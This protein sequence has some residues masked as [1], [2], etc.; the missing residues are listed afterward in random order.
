MKRLEKKLLV[1]LLFLSSAFIPV[2]SNASLDSTDEDHVIDAPWRTT[3]QYLPV[4]FFLPE[5]KSSKGHTLKAFRLYN[6][7]PATKEK[8]SIFIDRRSDKDDYFRC[9]IDFINPDGKPR[10]NFF[11]GEEIDSFWHYIAR[12]PVACIG[13]G[14][15]LG[16][17][18]VHYLYGEI[19]WDKNK[20]SVPYID[21]NQ[22]EFKVLRV[23]VTDKGFA[24]FSPVDHQFDVH[25]HTIA[26]QTSWSPTNVNAARSK[27]GG[28]LAML[29]ES[30]YA[31]G[32]VDVELKD[33]NWSD[34]KNKIITTDHNVF[35]SGEAYDSGTRPGYGPTSYKNGGQQEFQWYRDN[36]GALGGEEITVQGAHGVPN[37]PQKER[38]GSHLLSYGS[39][40]IDGPW[41]GGKFQIDIPAAPDPVGVPNQ[42]SISHA[43]ERMGSSNGFGY[44]SHPESSGIGWSK[45]Y[46][47]KAIGLAQ[48][49]DGS[50]TSVILQKNGSEFVLKGLQVWNQHKDMTSRD[51]GDIED[52]R[53]SR[54]DP[55]TPAKAGQK[56][57]FDPAWR[58]GLDKTYKQ[59]KH[60][61][62]RGLKYYFEDSPEHIFIRKLYLSAGT[63]AHGDFNDTIENGSATAEAEA[64]EM[65]AFDL[66]H[67]VASNNAF[68]RFRTYT[69]TSQR[70]VR[71][72]ATIP[73]N[74]PSF[75]FCENESPVAPSYYPV[76]DYKE[77][78][79]VVTDGPV[80]RFSTDANC[81]FD[82]D[83]HQLDWHDDLCIWENHDGMIG[84]RGK[85]D[86]GNTMLA[87][88][89][90]AGVMMRYDWIG[91]NDYLPDSE[92]RNDTMVFNLVRI[93]P[94]TPTFSDEENR[95]FRPGRSGRSNTARINDV[96][97]SHARIEFPDKTALILEGELGKWPHETKFVTNPI[98]IAPYKIS[99]DPVSTCPIRPGQL[100]VTVE[101][102]IS[103]D[104]TLPTGNP[105]ANLVVSA[106][107]MKQTGVQKVAR[108]TQR[109][110]TR[111]SGAFQID[112]EAH[113]LP[114]TAAAD[115]KTY[116]GIRVLVK[117]LDQRGNSTD[118]QYEI[119]NQNSRWQAVEIP[120]EFGPDLIA[121]AKYTTTNTMEIPCGAGW[122]S[123]NPKQKH[124]QSFASYAIVV[125]QVYDMHM[126]YLNPIARTVTMARPSSPFNLIIN[127]GTLNDK[128]IG[129][130][131]KPAA[132]E[133]S[134]S[135][136]N[137]KTC[138]DFGARC[139]VVKPA[140]GA[141][142]DLCRWPAANS[143]GQCQRTV[144]L[145]TTAQSKYAK[146]HPGVV[147]AGAAGACITEAR[148][149]ENRIQ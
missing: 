63:D 62:Q 95:E 121:D 43:I 108:V 22:K 60:L 148:N 114:G 141:G 45:T 56:F 67:V 99:V 10:R 113:S 40:H 24:K 30:A 75:P 139:E 42:I 5:F 13:I 143:A 35:F 117:P 53:A 147:A 41:H 47:E 58:E 52:S 111:S 119:S 105:A 77:G 2:Q 132:K 46:Y 115:E 93:Y 124:D 90:N 32:L 97:A 39:P 3:R 38:Q 7:D 83:I 55:Y 89:G 125:D 120:A 76:E 17:P 103:M 15:A 134:C 149:L 34:Y 23:V 72:G 136:R 61:L 26:E 80:G 25:V 126:N 81:R 16:Q 145:W 9:D 1:S 140:N 64:A 94:T 104:T 100:K 102:G 133:K 49:N 128:V 87:P 85:F 18:G 138:G 69:L 28:P 130:A 33:G 142:K 112:R 31:L 73:S 36:L 92:G 84:G 98:W 4:L 96:L 11:G 78:N 110:R 137:R 82:S 116:G 51:S 50:A 14:S 21:I 127:V 101:F 123:E 118:V 37:G 27:F 135:T 48:F 59:Y 57:E 8:K 70:Y 12:V 144:G 71:A 109:S 131:E 88:V 79:T 107:M 20:A 19:E 54:F 66:N 122:N 86:G 106:R 65:F 74:C 29:M 6:Y 44:A 129:L 146:K 68:G 91:K